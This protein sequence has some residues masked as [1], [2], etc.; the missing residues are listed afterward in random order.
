MINQN[1]KSEELKD[2]FSSTLKQFLTDIPK[3]SKGIYSISIGIGCLLLFAYFVSI[4]YVPIF[5]L[6]SAL[7]IPIFIAGVGLMVVVLLGFVFVLPG[8]MLNIFIDDIKDTDKKEKLL[9]YLNFQ[10]PNGK[11]KLLAFCFFAMPWLINLFLLAIV[12][13]VPK[14]YFP[15]IKWVDD[16]SYCFLFVPLILIPLLWKYILQKEFFWYNPARLPT[17]AEWVNVRRERVKDAVDCIWWL[18]KDPHPKANNRKVLQPYS[19]SMQE[20]LK[21]GYKAKL[22]PS[23][24]DISTKFSRDNGGAIPPNLLEIANT[25]SNSKY[26]RACRQF[27]LKPH[28]ARYPAGVPEFFIKF[29]TEPN[30]LV[31]DPFAGSNVTG[32]VAEKLNRRWIAFELVEE[33]LKGSRFRFEEFCPSEIGGN[34]NGKRT[35]KQKEND[36]LFLY[37]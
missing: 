20:L 23:G 29:L 15:A 32:E 1:E 2:S 7:W 11:Q 36:H 16:I 34:G 24:H 22:R 18:S 19:D 27:G 30:D 37:K 35:S 3:I 31:I 8:W 13:Y 4:N 28:P 12:I 14:N 25:E 26:L 21:R 33:Y 5:D 6:S 10:D 17:P 9:K